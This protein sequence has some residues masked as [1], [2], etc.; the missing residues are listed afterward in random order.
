[1]DGSPWSGLRHGDSGALSGWSP[2]SRAGSPTEAQRPPPLERKRHGA[3]HPSTHGA[4]HPTATTRLSERRQKHVPRK[5]ENASGSGYRTESQRTAPR[6]T[7]IEDVLAVVRSPAT[8]RQPSPGKRAGTRAK[9]ATAQLIAKYFDP[10]VMPV[11]EKPVVVPSGATAKLAG[12]DPSSETG[13]GLLVKSM[14]EKAKPVPEAKTVRITQKLRDKE[15]ADIMQRLMRVDLPSRHEGAPG[16]VKKRP[17]TAGK[18]RPPP[19]AWP[20]F[21][22]NK[23]EVTMDTVFDERTPP[24][25]PPIQPDYPSLHFEVSVTR[26]DTASPLGSP[27]DVPS[28]PPSALSPPG[29]RNLLPPG[30]RTWAIQSP[31]SHHGAM[32]DAGVDHW[33]WE[34]DAGG[35]RQRGGGEGAAIRKFHSSEKK[36]VEEGV[37]DAGVEGRAASVDEGGQVDALG[38]LN[39]EPYNLNP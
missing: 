14:R 13:P 25:S 26:S 8:Q 20:G 35:V 16:S 7:V 19:K 15:R 36:S 32:V 9:S 4:A 30:V 38:T 3:A 34:Q 6:S 5:V 24:D 17:A 33:G 31:P 10:L 23:V 28:S 27:V 1:M 2:V 29:G 22:G 11:K 39:S 37:A 21:F 12:A 18:S